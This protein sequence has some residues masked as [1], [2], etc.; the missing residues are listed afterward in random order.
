V[1]PVKIEDL[2]AQADQVALVKV[3][4]G[5]SEHYSTAVYKAIVETGF[6]GTAKGQIIFFGPYTGYRIGS[7]YLLFLKRGGPQTSDTSTPISYGPLASVSAIMY[8]GY[9]ALAVGYECVFDGT[10][11]TQTCDDSVQI[12]PDQIVLPQTIKTFPTGDATAITNYKKWI[13]KDLF[14]SLLH[15]PISR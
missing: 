2:Y 8:E 11:I 6:K 3:L 1:A 7:E 13:R 9:A 4:S 14:I 5:D 12:N 10:E 15:P